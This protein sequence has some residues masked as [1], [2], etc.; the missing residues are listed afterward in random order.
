MIRKLTA[1]LAALMIAA[2]MTACVPAGGLGGDSGDTG[3]GNGSSVED[4]GNG[5]GGTGAED[6]S[7]SGSGSGGSGAE[8][9]SGS[10]GGNGGG[11]GSGDSGT[12]KAPSEQKV[13]IEEARRIALER[14]PGATKAS[15]KYIE[16]DIDDGHVTYEGEIVYEGT[17]YEFEISAEDGT[18]L[19]WEVD[20]D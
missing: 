8:D 13:S 15:I 6:G 7:C 12:D 11:S 18:I 19:E 1:L 4:G 17:E 10:G 20:R 2:F 9:E 3:S 14:V 5:S 16:M